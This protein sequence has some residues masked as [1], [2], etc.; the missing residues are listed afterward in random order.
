MRE[1]YLRHLERMRD[2]VFYAAFNAK[3]LQRQRRYQRDPEFCNRRNLSTADWKMRKQNGLPIRPRI[4]RKPEGLV[5]A[6]NRVCS[7][8]VFS[9]SFD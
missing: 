3:R 9:C 8:M 2:P 4:Q 5:I 6:P 1:K 7:A